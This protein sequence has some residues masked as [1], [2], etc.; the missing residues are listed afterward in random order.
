[1]TAPK[2]GTVTCSLG[3]LANGASATV[4]IVVTT[5]T[6]GPLTNTATV[7]ETRSSRVRS[8][9]LVVRGIEFSSR[10]ADQP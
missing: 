6:P 7:M 9:S 3:K 8:A 10:P 5:T 2:D 1:M 4:Q